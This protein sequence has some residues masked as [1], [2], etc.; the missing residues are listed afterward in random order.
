MNAQE[1]AEDADNIEKALREQARLLRL[2]MGEAVEVGKL[3]HAIAARTDLGRVQTELHRREQA[4]RAAN[5]ETEVERIQIL[6][7]LAEAD[8]SWVAASKYAAM[9]S[10]AR[11]AGVGAGPDH[12]AMSPEDWRAAVLED[13]QSATD[14]DLELYAHEWMVR[15]GMRLVIEG[16]ESRIV[17]A[18]P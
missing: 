4:K 16:Q 15:N 7:G 9:E 13:A 2:I 10:A 12:A 18:A 5:A 8:G 14:Q 6:R 1:P 17:R 11:S 3:H